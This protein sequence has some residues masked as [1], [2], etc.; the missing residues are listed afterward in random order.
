[1]DKYSSPYKH[2]AMSAVAAAVA[3]SEAAR[4]ATDPIRLF[5]LEAIFCTNDT[6]WEKA[7]GQLLDAAKH[8]TNDDV[9]GALLLAA[10]L[11]RAESLGEAKL[12]F[13]DLADVVASKWTCPE[14]K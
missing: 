14:G 6:E 4:P 3:V 5:L 7:A 2:L 8:V 9:Y 12:A 13:R 1:M 10:A 11:L